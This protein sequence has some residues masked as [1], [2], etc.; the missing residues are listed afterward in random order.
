MQATRPGPGEGAET[1]QAPQA[2]PAYSPP[3]AAPPLAL[4]PSVSATLVSTLFC[5]VVAVSDGD[6]LIV[7]CGAPG[8]H[9]TQRVRVVSID[10][11]ESR[12]AFGQRSRQNLAQ[13][14]LRREATLR[15][16]GH[17]AYGRLL[18]HVECGGQDVAERQVAAGLAWVYAP[19]AGRY[20]GLT[21]LQRQARASRTGLW[22]QKRPL[23]PWDYRR[24]NPHHH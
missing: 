1:R 5:L 14:C 7:R 9:A 8:P 4:R 19:Q 16:Q 18:A 24:R 2:Q 22:S 12:Q 13:L 6:S 21:A 10:A 20:P 11:P 15:T 23:A 3:G 17:D